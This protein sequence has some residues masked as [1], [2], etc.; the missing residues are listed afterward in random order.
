MVLRETLQTQM[1][2]WQSYGPSNG[3]VGMT[4]IRNTLADILELSGVHNVDRHYNPMSAEQERVLLDQAAQSAQQQPQQGDPGQ[5]IIQAEQVKASATAQAA[6]IRGMV[7]YQKAVMQDDRERD[8]MTQDLAIKVAEILAKTGVQ[9]NTAAI[10]AEQAA[11]PVA[12]Q[13]GMQPN[14]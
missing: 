5:A 1:G 4:H 2:I 14:V 13:P 8:R 6:Q 12:M 10:K 11:P 3:I 7:D 9:L